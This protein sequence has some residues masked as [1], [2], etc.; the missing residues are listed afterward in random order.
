MADLAA[1]A[2]FAADFL[3]VFFTGDA[4]A[5]E[6]I[7]ALADVV[8]F[9][10]FGLAAVA[11]FFG[12]AFAAGA[13]AAAFFTVFPDVALVVVDFL[14]LDLPANFAEPVDPDD[15]DLR[16]AK[17]L[18]SSPH[19][20]LAGSLGHRLWWQPADRPAPKTENSE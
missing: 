15:E 13:L 16:F 4:L 3:T 11:A 1:V 7:A 14:G 8:A 9:F 6:P 18:T 19:P 12:A 2:F 20:L 5:G 10:F 17:L